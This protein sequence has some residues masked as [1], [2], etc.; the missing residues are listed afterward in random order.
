[1]N[2]PAVA[3]VVLW[4]TAANLRSVVFAI[5]PVLPDIRHD[6]A[7]SFSATGALTSTAIAVMGFGSIPGAYV[8]RLLGARRT[9]WVMAFGIGAASALRLAR[10]QA[11]WVFVG[12]GLLALAVS[13]SQPAAAVLV[14]RWFIDRLHRATSVYANGILVGGTIGAAATPLIATAFGWRASFVVWAGI[15][16]AVGT[17]WALLM[18]RSDAPV[19]RFHLLDA[20]RSGRAWQITA[21][22]AFQNFAYFATAAWLPFLLAGR[23]PAYVSW[24]FTC[25]NLLP[26]FPLL[27]LPAVRWPFATSRAFYAGSGL[28][29]LAGAAGLALGLR[30][31]AWW[32]AFLVGLGCAAAF[33][34]SM[35]LAPLVAHGEAE[36]G[37]ITAIVFTFG[38]V[39]AFGSPLLSGALVDATADVRSAFWPPVAGAILMA[40]LGLLVPGLLARRG[41]AEAAA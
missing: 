36:A 24:V 30:D 8:G 35:A 26:I 23:P 10:P 12:T 6:F 2:R 40:V 14:R 37:A 41:V 38:Y 34:G 32:L 5:Q 13:F 31:A 15:S 19:P 29:V 39:L 17:A 20:L 22:F 27:I 1:M 28:I 9:V 25:L 3:L 7:L 18:P 16:A 21:L 33:V 4:L 11:I